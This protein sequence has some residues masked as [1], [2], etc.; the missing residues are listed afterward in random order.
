M[1]AEFLQL[2]LSQ[3][4][5]QESKGLIVE[6]RRFIAQATQGKFP[7]EVVE[8]L[9]GGS[10]IPFI[11]KDGQLR[12]LVVGGLLRALISKSLLEFAKGEFRL[13][14]PLQL[15]LGNS[16]RSIQTAI[17]R[18]WARNLGNKVLLKVDLRNAYG[19]I[20]RASCLQTPAT[21]MCGEN[22]ITNTTGVQQ[23]DPL[24][25]HCS[26]LAFILLLKK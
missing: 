26:V 22:S 3:P 17:V 8:F 18:S 1:R 11:K 6:L 12:P 5:R 21:L 23:G 13:L 25:P 9:C 19:T 15:G 14:A 2:A 4:K 10:L 16:N 20:S 7:N 24:A